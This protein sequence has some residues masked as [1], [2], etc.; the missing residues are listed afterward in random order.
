MSDLERDKLRDHLRMQ[1]M[2]WMFGDNQ[3][4]EYVMCGFPEFKGLMNMTDAELLEELGHHEEGASHQE[5]AD[6]WRKELSEDD[7]D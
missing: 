1:L 5:M 6:A 4:K 3:E 2:D 7:E